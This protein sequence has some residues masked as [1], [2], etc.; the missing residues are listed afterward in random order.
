MRARSRS[1]TDWSRH[2]PEHMGWNRWTR[3]RRRKYSK[4]WL[5][6]YKRESFEFYVKP[7]FDSIKT[8]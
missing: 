8:Q 1:Q 4:R 3:K 7:Y 5:A 6:Q 2:T